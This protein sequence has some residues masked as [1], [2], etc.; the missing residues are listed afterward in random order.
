MASKPTVKKNTGIFATAVCALVALMV[1]AYYLIQTN[2]HLD[3]QAAALAGNWYQFKPAWA[4]QIVSEGGFTG[5]VAALLL[6]MLQGGVY[7]GVAF[8]GTYFGFQHFTRKPAQSNESVATKAK[9][10]HGVN[11]AE[12]KGSDLMVILP[13]YPGKSKGEWAGGRIDK[14]PYEQNFYRI[15][16]ASVGTR[17]GI[18]LTPHKRLYICIYAMLKAHP[19]VPA[20]IGG[21]H[22]DTDL[23]EHSLSVAKKVQAYFAERGKVEPLAQIAGLAHDLD[24]LLAY[25]KNGDTWGKNVN[26]THHNKYAAY[27]VSTQPEFRELPEE[28]RNILVLALR[29]YHDPEN[30]PIGASNRTETLIQALRMCDGYA[31]KEEKAAAVESLTDEQMESIEKALLDTICELNING[32]LNKAGHAGGWTTPALEYVITPMSTVLELLG[33]HLPVDLNRKL[34][35][36]HETRTFTHP[37]SRLVSQRLNQLGLLMTSYKSF[38]SEHGLYDCRIGSTRFRAV[39]M[40]QKQELEK[41]RPGLQEKWGAAAYRVRIT[42]ATADN[43][44]QGDNDVDEEDLDKE[45]EA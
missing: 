15:D 13:K 11:S 39:L 37:A 3:V 44:V 38:E 33:K 1:Y 16:K 42:S 27:I 32:Y 26:A 41:L 43:T 6:I 17:E 31:I 14:S 23:F 35:L 36:D 2:Q 19:D 7:F 9:Q 10:V 18:E 30:L 28:D 25:K 24:K 20:S 45:K 40:I 5:T 34:Q 22:A 12:I 29:Y 4:K 8:L 21:H